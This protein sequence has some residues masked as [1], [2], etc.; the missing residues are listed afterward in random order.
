MVGESSDAQ[1]V[2]S[3]KLFLSIGGLVTLGAR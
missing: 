1:C 3:L 2:H